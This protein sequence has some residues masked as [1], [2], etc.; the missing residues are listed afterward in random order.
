MLQLCSVLLI[1]I[2]LVACRQLDDNDVRLSD[3]TSEISAEVEWARSVASLRGDDGGTN[4]G[5]LRNE[6]LQVL[7]LLEQRLRTQGVSPDLAEDITIIE[8][9]IQRLYA[10]SNFRA[11]DEWRYIS[12]DFVTL[13]RELNNPDA[14]LQTLNQIIAKLGG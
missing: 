3:N 1:V 2:S 4:N 13:Q 10:S 9:A 12:G 11:R 8:G 5:R 7:Y 6:I 14:A